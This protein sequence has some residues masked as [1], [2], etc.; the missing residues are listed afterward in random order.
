MFYEEPQATSNQHCVT[1]M[2]LLKFVPSSRSRTAAYSIPFACTRPSETILS[3][4]ADTRQQS[5][6]SRRT[7]AILL[8]H[9]IIPIKHVSL[10]ALST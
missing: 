9:P 1:A 5:E 7:M 2:A 3:A 4:S 6:D 8:G 10:E